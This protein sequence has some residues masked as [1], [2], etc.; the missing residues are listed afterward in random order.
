MTEKNTITL[1]FT[2]Q[3]PERVCIVGSKGMLGQCLTNRYGG[4][5]DPIFKFSHEDLD[6]TDELAV[7]RMV[8]KVQPKV[9]I[10]AA[11]YT[12]VDGCEDDFWNAMQVNGEGPANLA[13][14]CDKFDCKLVHVSTDYV[15]DGKSDKPYKED[16]ETNPLSGYG[17]SKLLGEELIRTYLPDDHI[18]IRTS[19]LFAAHG[20]NFAK[21][22]YSKCQT[23]EH[24]KVVNDQI[25][26][27]TL[28][29]DLAAAIEALEK[30]AEPGTYHFRNSGECSWY[31]FAKAIVT[32]SRIDD[33]C[34]VLPVTSK[35]FSSPTQR[36]AYS[37]LDITKFS[38][39]V[40]Y[41]PRHWNDA[42][43]DC[44]IQ[45]QKAVDSGL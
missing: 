24:L 29:N 39:A 43:S 26:S 31:E 19:W 42:L 30:D 44:I 28:V 22:I 4:R 32:L 10:N 12:N 9:I 7:R 15:F 41:T 6:I 27:P 45:I 5:T 35:E 11:A 33:R 14:A 3:E 8:R 36:P 13:K 40:N 38:Q 21:T 37:V 18:I 20:R 25:G 16:D 17:E 2:C 34:K 1:S 23:E